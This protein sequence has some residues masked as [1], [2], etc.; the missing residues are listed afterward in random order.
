MPIKQ[1]DE[2]DKLEEVIRVVKNKYDQFFSGIQKMPPWTERR[3]V[4]AFIQELHKQKMRDNS[5]RFRFNTLTA[6]YNQ[7]RELWGRRMREREEGP[8]EFKRRQAALNEPAPPPP[9]PSAARSTPSRE[10]SDGGESYVKVAQGTNGEEVRKLFEQIKQENSKLGKANNV[11]FEQLSAMVEKQ[12]EMVR[13]RYN[14]NAVA[15]K[16]E[17]VDGKVKLKAKPLQ[18]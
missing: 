4:E 6:R 18:E 13:S 5:R 11:T 10:T 16:V 7:Y 2:L 12:S 15:F 9:P 17:T 14:V 3:A 8:I 1:D